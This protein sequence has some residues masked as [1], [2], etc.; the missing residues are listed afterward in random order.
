M[1]SF[2]RI[3]T[4]ITL[5]VMAALLFALVGPVQA[6]QAGTAVEAVADKYQ[7]DRVV[8]AGTSAAPDV[9]VKVFGPTDAVYY[10]RSVPVAGGRY[11][12]E[13]TLAA[14]AELGRYTVIA[15]YGSDVARTT[16]LVLK[17]G[18]SDEEHEVEDALN[19]LVIGFSN[20]DTW[21]SV[22]SS[23]FLLSVGKHD[24][25]VSWVSSQPDVIVIGAPQGTQIT[26]QVERQDD[27]RSVIVTA[28]VSKGGKKA[29]RPF[30][31]IV[32]SKTANKVSVT[33][34]VRTVNV[35]GETG[36]YTKPLG[37][38][39][40][41]MSDGTKIDKTIVDV[42]SADMIVDRGQETGEKFSRLLMD[43]LPGDVPDELAVEVQAGSVSTLANYGM[44][45]QLESETAVLTIANDVLKEMRKQAIDLYFRI[46]PVRSAPQRE[47]LAARIVGEPVVRQAQG[48]AQAEVVGTPQKIETNYTSY[49]TK[50]LIPFNGSVPP[51]ASASYL[52]ALRIFIEHH[53]GEKELVS[54]TIVN[55]NGAPYGIEIE[56]SKFSTFALVRLG[57]SGGNG[58]SNNGG[59]SDGGNS[60]NGNGNGGPGSQEG[61]QD[62]HTAYVKGYLD[63][64][65]KPENKITRAEMA[66]LLVRVHEAGQN[67]AIAFPDVPG[68]YWAYENVMD[69]QRMG[70]MKGYPNGT[71]KPENKITRAEMAVIVKQWLK[72][73]DAATTNAKDTKGHWAEQTIARVMKSGVMTGYPD[74]S[75]KPDQPLT[76]AEAVTILNRLLKRG[77]LHGVTE[78]SWPDVPKKH[79]AFGEIE[80]ASKNHV[81]KPRAEGGETKAE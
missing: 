43:H 9:I 5:L 42:S 75:F 66:S 58:G 12:T 27:E 59:N 16:F 60:D 24:T 15:G 8:L 62:R 29:S 22:T 52:N 6:A 30:L 44:T 69:V 13:F 37:I 26:G 80:E 81:F 68:K 19:S 54:G 4:F 33:D 70:L 20:G 50:L 55:R 18:A 38:T 53:D 63:G 11:T 78:P 31:L 47:A 72:L 57:S 71:F 1:N 40:I 51:G 77:P 45:F 56:L 48:G 76:R 25:Q 36:G 10:A 79:W 21:E 39:R 2:S 74:G 34:N 14:D 28:T 73:N 64:T 41:V 3:R 7:G 35:V 49:R 46:V 17:R 67:S 23:L 32:K 65:F 61:T